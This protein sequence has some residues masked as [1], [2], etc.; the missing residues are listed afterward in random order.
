MQKTFRL[1]LVALRILSSN[2]VKLQNEKYF[3]SDDY[4]GRNIQF[5]VREFAMAGICNV[6][7]CMVLFDLIIATFLVFA[8]YLRPAIRLSAMMKLPF[9]FLP[10]IVFLSV[11]MVRHISRLKRLQCAYFIR[12][13]KL[14]VLLMPKK[15]MKLGDL[16]QCF[17]RQF[18]SY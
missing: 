17:I 10:M 11:K 1:S 16:R 8:D 6:F 12:T 4:S 9:M 5:G 2:N 14:F 13:A 18:A 15:R 7:I 3:S